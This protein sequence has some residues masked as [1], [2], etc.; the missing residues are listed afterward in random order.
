MIDLKKIKTDTGAHILVH[1]DENGKV[2][3]SIN[4]EYIEYDA[5]IALMT[6]TAF[7]MCNDLLSGITSSNLKQLIARSTENYFIANKLDSNSIIIIV[8][9]EITKI[10]LLLKYMNSI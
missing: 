2:I 10:G 9:N 4:P 7:S 1:A 3:D 8:S 5:N 6:E